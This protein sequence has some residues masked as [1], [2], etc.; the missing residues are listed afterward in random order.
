MSKIGKKII[1]I[2]LMATI[3]LSLIPVTVNAVLGTPTVDPTLVKVGDEVEVDG[4]GVTAG[5]DVNIYW[6]SVAAWDGAKGLLGSAEADSDGT[7]DF[8]FDIPEATNGNHYVWVKDLDTGDTER[9]D[10]VVVE[11]DVDTSVNS[12]LETDDVV[13]DG[14]GFKGSSDLL[15]GLFDDYATAPVTF[16][17]T[18]DT[19][20]TG[21]GDEDEFEFTTEE[22]PLE[23]GSVTVWDGVETFTDDG[24]GDLTGNLGGDGTVN[25]VTGEIEVEFNTE[26]LDGATI[27]VSYNYYENVVDTVNLLTTTGDT[28][29][30]GTF[31][32]SVKIPDVEDMDEGQYDLVSFD[33]DGNVFILTFTIGAT[34]SLE[35]DEG[36]VGLLVELEAKGFDPADEVVFGDIT[37]DGI[38]C[39]IYDTPVEVEN[40]GE[41]DL[42]LVIPQVDDEDD[43]VL[44]VTVGVI[45]VTADFEVTEL[46]EVEVTPDYGLQGSKVTVSGVNF[47]Q[48][49]DEEVTVTLGG[50]GE[51][52]FDLDNDGTFEGSFTIPGVSQGVHPLLAAAGDFNIDDS[53]NFKAGLIVVVATPDEVKAGQMVT[54]TGTGFSEDEDF[55]AEFGDIEMTDEEEIESDGTFTYEYYVPTIDPGTY[56]VT[57]T[58]IDA[59]IDVTTE[60]TV[61]EDTMVELDPAT[62]PNEYRIIIRGWNFKY[63]DGLEPDFT[64]YNDED[65]WDI[66]DDVFFYDDEDDDYET[67]DVEIDSEEGNFT[68]WWEVYEDDDLDLGD[69]TL[70]IE[71]EDD[72][73]VEVAL[74]IVVKTVTVMPRKPTFT[75]GDT[76][77]FEIVNSFAQDESYIKIWEPNGDLYWQTDDFLEGGATDAWIK[78]GTVYRV[79]YYRQTAGGNPMILLGDAPLGTWKWTMYDDDNDEIDSGTFTVAAAPEAV[80]EERINELGEDIADVQDEIAS[81]KSDVADAKKSADAAKAAADASTDAVQDIGKTASGAKDAADAAKSAADEAKT[82]A[83]GIQNLVYIAIGAS[84]IAAA[85]A[86]FGIMQISSKVAG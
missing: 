11:P 58:D 2:I 13:V 12:G 68:A 16:S 73:M 63:E 22:A 19:D 61:T 45:T 65:D 3:I 10:A 30:V 14:T 1:P 24:D 84:V 54:F 79:P 40:D 85:A 55:S 67:G 66:T 6:D 34:V 43:Y 23:I 49:D 36:E 51:K 5:S 77:A 4:S 69:Y 81:V 25:Y 7:F 59:E 29:S 72:W 32:E 74:E 26:P 60:V 70:L 20:E 82:A 75:I 47:P 9:S 80:L 35:Y 41:F 38:A 44:T 76:I 28:N 15:I 8:E 83:S 52:D 37:L 86:I 33:K 57:F 64:L 46:A 56:T 62:A 48:D 42:T 18:E 31:S 27:W 71:V 78:V 39:Y 21:D 53:T 17:G 50:L